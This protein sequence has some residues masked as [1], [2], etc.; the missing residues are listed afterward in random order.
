MSVSSDA[1]LGSG[2][3]LTVNDG[4][5]LA[6][7]GSSIFTRQALLDGSTTFNVSAGK[8]ANWTGN[9]ATSISAAR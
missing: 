4:G 5:T 1:N 6:I 9:I 7:T 3:A 8:T 2:G